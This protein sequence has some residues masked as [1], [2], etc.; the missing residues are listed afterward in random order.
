MI[1]VLYMVL[2]DA[3]DKVSFESDRSILT[4][5]VHFLFPLSV[6]VWNQ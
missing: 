3:V 4:F 2:E 1:Q 5:I 6:D